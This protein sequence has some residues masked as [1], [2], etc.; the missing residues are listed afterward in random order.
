[1]LFNSFEFLI[2]F[3]IVF[4]IYWLLSFR[5]FRWQNYMLLIAS[6]IFYGYWDW[7]FLSLIVIS[8]IV[9][10]IAG[11]KIEALHESEDAN[12]NVFKKRWLIFSICTNLGI[13]GFFKYFNFF[14]ETFA[15]LLVGF[16][17]NPDDFYLNIILPIGIS[18]YTFQTM[19]YTIDIYRGKMKS[20]RR[21]FDFALYVSFFPQL[22]AGP[23]ERASNL[24]PRILNKRIFK[25]DQLFEG[26]HLIMIG[27]FKKVYVADNLAPLIDRI[28]ASSDPTGFEA[29]VGGWGFAVQVYGD[30][31]GYSDIARGCAK[32]LG[33]DLMVNFNHPY[34]APNPVERW[35]RWHIS[36]SSWLRDYLYI[37]LGGN[38][39]GKLKIYRNLSITMLLGGLWHG[40]AWNFVLW[41]A[42]EG[43]MLL[44]HRLIKPL[45][46]RITITKKYI[47]AIIRRIFWMALMFQFVS[48]G[49][50]IFRSHSLSHMWQLMGII[51]SDKWTMDPTLLWPLTKC[52]VPLFVYEGFQ[53]AVSRDNW[54]QIVRIPLG[55][56]AIVYGI[57]FYLVAFQG[58]PAQNFVYFQF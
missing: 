20:T 6:Y 5:S 7:R 44:V 16:D 36:L 57:L 30:F 52:V 42:W 47:P 33:I 15:Q 45:L 25:W 31:S 24:L 9:D 3:P 18:F 12:S 11:L 50:T 32:C 2:F 56:R 48:L 8:T 35:K 54:N 37:S 10:Y 51:I 29:L 27:F 41:G 22:V 28:F 43:A 4:S 38:R 34:T 53:F 49:L 23:I 13:L 1:M 19:S 40:A 46:D 58:A 26:L 21:F 14:T 39:H 17:I 55:I